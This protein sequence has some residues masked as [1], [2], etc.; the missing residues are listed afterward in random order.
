MTKNTRRELRDGDE[1]EISQKEVY[2]FRYPRHRFI[3][4]FEEAYQ[5]GSMLGSG[6][7]AS[8]YKATEKSSGK[9]VAVKVFLNNKKVSAFQQE[10]AIL[11][12]VN[13][14]NVLSL[15]ETFDEAS[16]VYLILEF[17]PK[18][19]LFNLII[20]RSKLSE[21]ETRKVFL[22]L[23]DGLQYLVSS[24]NMCPPLAHTC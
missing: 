18:G 13:H 6:H 20:E 14:R 16:K 21:S 23:F 8:V 17:A 12:S 11:M 3:G 1:I 10:V 19:E 4:R 2:L 9:L 5:L 24:T 15:K 22:Q 7:F